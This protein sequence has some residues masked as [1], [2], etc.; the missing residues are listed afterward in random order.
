MHRENELKMKRNQMD[1]EIRLISNQRLK[2]QDFLSREMDKHD[3][4]VLRNQDTA[5]TDLGFSQLNSSSNLHKRMKNHDREYEVSNRRP[6]HLHKQFS[7]EYLDK[8]GSYSPR[9]GNR[10][11]SGA[12]RNAGHN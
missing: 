8:F 2:E 11:D 3:D 9:N 10:P 7:T 5:A 4:L 6:R 12:L 1:E